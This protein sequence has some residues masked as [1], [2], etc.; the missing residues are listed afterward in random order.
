MGIVKLKRGHQTL[1]PKGAAYRFK[2]ARPSAMIQQT[3]KG[4]LTKERWGEICAK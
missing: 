1:L 3:L 2:A 4:D